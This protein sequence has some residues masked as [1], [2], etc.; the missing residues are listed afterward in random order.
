MRVIGI[1]VC[2]LHKVRY[3]KKNWIY[4]Y[5]S[6]TLLKQLLPGYTGTILSPRPASPALYLIC[7]IK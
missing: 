5:D 4:Q 6:A 2:K 3:K 1:H 7:S